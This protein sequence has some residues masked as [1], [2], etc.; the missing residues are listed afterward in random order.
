[1]IGASHT[2]TVEVDR[3]KLA[4][5][6]G[7]G[8]LEVFATPMMIAAMEQAASELLAKHLQEG[9]TSVGTAVNIAHTAATPLGMRVTA[10]AT[11]T[12]VDGKRVDFDVSA[13]DE[14]GEIGHGTHSRFIVDAASF[15]QKTDAKQ[16]LAK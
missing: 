15:Q 7:S 9:Q 14:L 12:A 5:S 13:S 1:M 11:V 6:V 3:D 2:V 10:T 16:E 8:V 4:C